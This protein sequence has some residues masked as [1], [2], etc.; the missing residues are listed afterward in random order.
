MELGKSI[1]D[2]AR[3]KRCHGDACHKIVNLIFLFVKWEN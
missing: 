1:F 2:L 3:I